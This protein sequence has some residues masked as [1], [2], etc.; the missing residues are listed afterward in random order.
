MRLIHFIAGLPLA[1]AVGLVQAD[2]IR[3]GS[4]SLDW[5]AGYTIKSAKPPFELAGPSGAKVL[6]TVMRPGASAANSPEALAKLHAM[7]E[8]ML[9]TEAQKAGRVV[10]PLGQETLP[11]GTRLRFTG[12]QVAKLFRSGY[13]LQYALM[14]RSG[15]IA[16]LTFEGSG[17]A[18][19][20]HEAIKGLF[21]TV[22]WNAGDGT[23]AE[24]SAFTDRA[25]ALLRA[26]IGDQPV[27][28]AGPLTL[29]IGDLQ[30]NLDRVYG[31]CR[32]NA[33]G[34]DD[35][36]QRYVQAVVDVSR[37]STLQPTREA[38]RVVVRTTE[39]A[40][41]AERTAA[42]KGQMI[43]R[44]LVEGLVAMPILDTPRSARLLGETDRK[45]LGLSQDQAYELGLANLRAT[46]K[47]MADVAKPLKR[48]AIGTLAGDFYE[49]GRLLLHADWAPLARAQGG[50]LIVALPAKD[51]LLY[52]AD[53]S[54]A[55]L[56]ALHAL[57][58]E[59]ARASAGRLS[60][61]LLRWTESGWQV[62]R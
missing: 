19:A 12:S 14:A 47:P 27:V 35:E 42:G 9:T 7:T 23:A 53:D 62:V 20:E 24:Q 13:F 18:A 21:R 5:P 43:R 30:A 58:N 56:D 11:D 6:V 46:L 4:L 52:S 38:L 37:K 44:P 49:S 2:E 22:Q 39:F 60:D 59:V 36:L 61:L 29:K 8:R 55:G 48:G 54:S 50:T 25:A 15:Q 57:S 31:F 16:F 26:Q 1:L 45:T 41:G 40:D 34:C 10:V 28:V 33:D 51:M 17:D 32:T 3:F